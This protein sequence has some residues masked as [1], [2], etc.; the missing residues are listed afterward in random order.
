M[1]NLGT[2]YSPEGNIAPSTLRVLSSFVGFASETYLGSIPPS[3]PR[4]KKKVN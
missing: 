1:S 3:L 4:E 2:L